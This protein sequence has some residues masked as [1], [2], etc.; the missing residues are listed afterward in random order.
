MMETPPTPHAAPL[1]ARRK[2]CVRWRGSLATLLLLVAAPFSLPLAA[3]AAP[4]RAGIPNVYLFTEPSQALVFDGQGWGHGVGLCQW[5]ARGRAL[6]GQT[7]EQIIAAYY[8]G[9]E[10]QQAIAP[11]TTIRVLLDTGRPLHPGESPRVTARD[12]PW[13]VETA[14]VPPVE[15]PP[16]GYLELSGDGA[17][18]E[19]PG[20]SVHAPDGATLADGPLRNTLVL[21][22]LEATT[23]FTVGYK[24]A[25]EVPGRPGNYYDTYRGELILSPRGD[26]LETI[27]RL[28]LQ[29][30]LKGVVPAEMPASWPVE[31]LKAQV[32]AARSYAVAQARNRAGERYDVDDTTRYQVYL[33]LNVER[34]NVNQ[35]VDSTAGQAIVHGGQV[36]QGFFFSTCAG[37]T[38]NNEAVWSGAPLP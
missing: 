4:P 28:A 19:G 13:Q 35:L 7:S 38:E 26:G 27:N 9:T 30:Y 14:G 2:A 5:G 22:P 33:G 24:P 10:V 17:D 37:W 8:R 3:S 36:I 11:E 29:D 18:G 16:G 25:A 20:Y 21:R 31:A 34:P 23:R 32:L 15:A 12:G 1:A 6:A